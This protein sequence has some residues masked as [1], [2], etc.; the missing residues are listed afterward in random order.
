MLSTKTNPA[1]YGGSYPFFKPSDLDAGNH[2]TKASEY[3]SD[4]GKL[5]SRQFEKGTILVCCIGSIGKCAVIDVDGTS[6]QQ[7]NALTPIMCDSDYLLY[8]IQSNCFKN[9]LFDKSRA[10][11]VEIIKK[12]KFDECI[13]PFPPL[14]EQIR[15]VE[16][17]EK[18]LLMI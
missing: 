17:I 10:T 12:S 13:I 1:N 3:L 4:I 15:I 5:A 16:V 7:I 6:N 2:I 18:T 11:T 8:V 14:K 9:Q